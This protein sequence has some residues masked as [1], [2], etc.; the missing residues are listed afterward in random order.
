MW[1]QLLQHFHMV[2][3]D[4][5]SVLYLEDEKFELTISDCLLEAEKIDMLCFVAIISSK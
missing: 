1:I 3:Y 5:A 2:G 4:A